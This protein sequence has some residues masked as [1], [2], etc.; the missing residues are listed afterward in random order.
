MTSPR[1]L[2]GLAC[3]LF[4]T[5]TSAAT[6]G[7]YEDFDHPETLDDALWFGT[8]DCGKKIVGAADGAVVHSGNC[9]R[10]NW[11]DGITDPITHNTST[12]DVSARYAGFDIFV[13]S[14]IQDE[15]FVDY[16][17][18]VDPGAAKDFGA[19]WMWLQG[20]YQPDPNVYNSWFNHLLLPPWEGWDT[21]QISSNNENVGEAGGSGT[22]VAHLSEIP[23]L[24][25]LMNGDSVDE[26][27]PGR[28]HHFQVY[29]RLNTPA[30]EANGILQFWLDG[31]TVLDLA[32]YRYRDSD[33]D[34]ISHFATPHMYGGSSPPPGSF[35]WQLD[36]LAVWD[37]MPD[38]DTDAGTTDSGTST[39]SGGG[40]GSGGTTAG[41]AGA[42]LDAGGGGG[43]SSGGASPKSDGSGDDSGCAVRP[44][45]APR[46]PFGF[47]LGLLL[48]AF[49]LRMSSRRS[50]LRSGK[51]C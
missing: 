23:G 12:S 38:G 40:S 32:D 46:T 17:A 16:W 6:R 21:W 25:A 37:G 41:D 13:S 24:V 4:S 28:W 39:G 50:Q 18:Y 35:G 51:V 5:A 30:S 8:N 22:R 48:V 34:H 47:V 43:T 26:W 1:L 49:G 36:E 14:W 20:T 31:V 29:V 7:F 44:D 3:L 15:M 45:H 42:N 19:K 27:F 9:L 2:F 10:G 11:K 33:D